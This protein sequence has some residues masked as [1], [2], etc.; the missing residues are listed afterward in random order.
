MIEKY[1]DVVI[2]YEEDKAFVISCDS[3]GAIG[4]KPNDILKT[5]EEIVG[6]NTL[7]VALSEIFSVGAKPLVISDTL[8]VEMDPSGE[9]ILDGIKKELEENEITDVI[10]TGSTEENFPVSVTGIGITAIGWAKKDNLKIKK[11]KSG[12]EVCLLGYPRVGKEVLISKDILSLKDFICISESEEIVEAIPVG[13]KGIKYEISIL[14]EMSNMQLNINTKTDI[15]FNKSA[16]P[17][18][19]CLVVY[20]SQNRAFIE[21]ITN[22]PITYLGKLF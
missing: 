17:S 5:D 3:L 14:E 21:K 1:R 18:T 13:S 15:N 10:L 22:K 16:G 9:K 7:K 12:M 11:I 2:I 8:M 6:R 4:N 19:C 20:E